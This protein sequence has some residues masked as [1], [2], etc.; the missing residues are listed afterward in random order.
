MDPDSDK[1]RNQWKA[2]GNITSVSSS[3]EKK[4]Q[5]TSSFLS[6]SNI[7]KHHYPSKQ[8]RVQKP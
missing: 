1:C 7:E 5:V 6:L 8:T 3:L 2:D 4:S